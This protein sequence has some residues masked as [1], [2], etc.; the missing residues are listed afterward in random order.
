MSYSA[1]SILTKKLA[2]SAMLVA[3]AVVGSAFIQ[4]PFLGSNCSPTQ[5]MVNVLC[6]VFL[7]PGWGV[8]VAFC[9]SLI[10]NLLSVGS[11]MAFPGSMI[12]AL[13]CGLVYMALRKRNND[14]VAIVTTLA[15]EMFGT[16]VLGGLCAYPVATLFMNVDAATTA[17]TAYIIPFLISTVV[18]SLIAGALVFA[19]KAGGA[20]DRMQRSLTPINHA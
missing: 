13:C 12:G 3:V 1:S 10:R 18:G 16:G 15:A 7:G 14:V 5:H 9:A 17:V 8:L 6:A 19:L 4:F 2:L 20:L 11:L